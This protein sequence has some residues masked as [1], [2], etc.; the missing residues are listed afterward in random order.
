[1]EPVLQDAVLETQTEV[2]SS[3]EAYC[4]R[5]PTDPLCGGCAGLESVHFPSDNHNF[6]I[7]GRDGD[8]AIDVDDR[9]SQKTK[10]HAVSGKAFLLL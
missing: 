4:Y 10:S 2:V 6:S 5:I 9:A 8:C 7:F 1:M 3:Y